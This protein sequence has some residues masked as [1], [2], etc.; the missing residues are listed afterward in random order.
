M[1]NSNSK[2]I[3]IVILCI[4][5]ILV[6]LRLLPKIFFVPFHVL[7]HT[8]KHTI[9]MPFRFLDFNH[10][11]KIFPIILS[12]LW[13]AVIIWVYK[14]AERRNMNG[15][16]WALL[17]FFGNVIGLLIYIIVRSDSLPSIDSTIDT[18]PCPDCGKPV[19]SRYTFCPHCGSRLHSVCTKC[20][21]PIESDWQVCPK[22][23]KKLG[24][25]KS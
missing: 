11:Y 21:Q 22:C 20:D 17:V 9:G 7:P 10:S 18:N 24:Q 16:I 4:L 3:G 14:D 19:A 23:G 5:I 8:I 6:F 2:S 25:K 15:L 12:L 13:L 1:S